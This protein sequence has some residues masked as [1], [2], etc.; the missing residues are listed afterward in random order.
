MAANMFML[1]SDIEGDAVEGNHENWIVLEGVNWNLARAVDMTDLGSNQRGHAN[2]NFGKVEV[3]TEL[4]KASCKLMLSVANGTVRPE[5]TIHQ[6]RSGDA[7][8]EGLAPY[9]IWT[10][11]STVVDS[12]SVSSSADAVPTETWTLAYEKIMVEYHG[13]DQDTAGLSKESEFKWNLRTGK[14]G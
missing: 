13:T 14:V 1:I 12:Y 7:E 10:L 11:Y 2:T 4:G 5:I 9:L 3:T 6:C 8:D